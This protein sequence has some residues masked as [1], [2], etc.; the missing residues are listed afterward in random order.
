MIADFAVEDHAICVML[1]DGEEHIIPLKNIKRA[2]CDDNYIM[3]Q[4]GDDKRGSLV[5]MNCK[6]RIIERFHNTERFRIKYI[7]EHLEHGLCAVCSVPVNHAWADYY[8]G[9]RDGHFTRIAE[10]EKDSV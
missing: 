8:Y 7:L 10:V 1:D 4:T 5:V 2:M 9:M 3:A 6:G